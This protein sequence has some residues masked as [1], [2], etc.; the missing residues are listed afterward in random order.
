MVTDPAFVR[1]AEVDLLI[2]DA[3]KA[4]RKLGWEPRTTFH[5][6][7]RLMVD[8]EIAGLNGGT[9]ESRAVSR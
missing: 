2:G 7:V 1:P 6:L 4:K 8:E 3:A 9:R 5:E